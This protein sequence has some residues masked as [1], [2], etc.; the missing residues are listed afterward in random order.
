[1]TTLADMFRAEGKIEG[2][3]TFLL[4]LLTRRFGVLPPE[5]MNKIEHADADTL[6]SW[7]DKILYAKTMDEVFVD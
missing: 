2:E 7:G 3:K 6:L 5:N 1:M 4:R